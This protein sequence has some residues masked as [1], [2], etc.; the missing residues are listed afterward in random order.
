MLDG[1]V[2]FDSA[3]PLPK[4]RLDYESPWTVWRGAVDP[5]A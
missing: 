3:L 4:N 2:A 1:A 5:P